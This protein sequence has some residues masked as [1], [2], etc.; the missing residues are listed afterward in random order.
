IGL[1]YRRPNGGLRIAIKPFEASLA[2]D[3]Q[4]AILR[5]MTQQSK[6]LEAHI[7]EHPSEWVWMHKRWKTRPKNQS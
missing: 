4:E 7:K 5:D 6:M 3:P 1:N 2:S